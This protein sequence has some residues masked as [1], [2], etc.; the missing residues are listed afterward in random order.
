[1]FS[2]DSLLWQ[3]LSALWAHGAAFLPVAVATL[4]SHWPILDLE[5]APVSLLLCAVMFSTWFGGAAP[6]LADQVPEL[7]AKSG[8]IPRGPLSG[9][10]LLP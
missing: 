6:G 3:K 8:L 5:S 10:W 9:P 1:M 4:V 7:T 2:S